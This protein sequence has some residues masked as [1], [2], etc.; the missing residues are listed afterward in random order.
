MQFCYYEKNRKIDVENDIPSNWAYTRLG[1]IITLKSGRD[2]EQCFYNSNKNGIPYI[3]GAS[4]IDK[5]GIFIN[6]WTTNPIVI[7]KQGELLIT[8]KGTIGAM[9]YN[10]IGDIHIARQI[11]SISSYNVTL[12]YIKIFLETYI[13]ILQAKAKSM[14]PGISRDDLLLAIIPIPPLKEQSRI[15]DVVNKIVSKLKDES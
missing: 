1:D 11:M 2:L 3:T 14:I 7:S 8:C 5:N 15:V 13:N 4:N 9:C 6:R 10:D 12:P